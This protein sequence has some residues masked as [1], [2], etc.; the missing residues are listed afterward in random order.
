MYQAVHLS[1]ECFPIAKVGGLGDVVGALPKYLNIAGISTCVILPKYNQKWNATHPSEV[2]HQGICTNENFY[3]EYKIHRYLDVH[4][5]FDVYLVDIPNLLFRDNIYGYDDDPVRFLFF[6]QAAINWMNNWAQKPEIIHCHDY[7]TGLIPFMINNCYDYG[8]LVGIKTVFT[9]HNGLYSG[10]F[11]IYLLS[12]FPHFPKETV[13]LLE[14]DQTI[15]PLATGIKCSNKVTTVSAGYL[16]ELKYQDNAYNWLYNEYG[17]KSKGI[18]NGIDTEVWNPKT[19]HYLIHLLKN[20]WASFKQKNKEAICKLVGLDANKPLTIFIG[21]LNTEKGGELVYQGIHDFLAGNQ[22]MNFYVL[23]SGANQIEDAIRRLSG[24]HPNNVANY[25]GYNEELAHRLY[26]AADFL[27]MPSLVEPC[28][29]NQMYALRYGTIPIVRAVGGLKDTVVDF[30]DFGGYGIRFNAPEAY[31]LV[32]SLY[33]AFDL[34]VDSDKFDQVRE[35]AVKLDFSW[36]KAVN[37]YI[38]IYKS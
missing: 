36:T 25:I 8:N 24:Y 4:L 1:A 17:F 12:Y 9:I 13:G 19:D 30:G 10:A 5:G 34:Y 15:N 14:W 6:Q 27:I 26:A 33:R 11:P 7:H 32:T 22:Q 29:L 2:I 35:L 18:V 37:N 31:D 21:R 20:D 23:G 28:G 16:D 3:V 38:E